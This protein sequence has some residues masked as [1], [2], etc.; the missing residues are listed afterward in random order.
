MYE[1]LLVPLDGSELAEVALPYAREIA[2]KA[3]SEITL[4]HVSESADSEYDRMH[5]VYIERMVE[6]T[7][8]G[9]G[10][11]ALEVRAAFVVGNDAEGIVDYA[12]RE[13]MGLIVMATH[14]RSGIRRWVLGSVADKVLRAAERPVL[15]VRSPG[16][17][18][19]LRENGI[20]GRV[21]VPLDGSRQGEAVIPYVEEFVAK[22]GGEVTLLHVVASVQFV[23]T[24]PGE[25][26]QMMYSAEEIEVS[27]DKAESYL[28]KVAGVLKAKGIKTKSEVGIGGSAEEIIRVADDTGADVVAMSTHGLSGVGRWALGSTADKVLQAGS[29]PVLLVRAS[30]AVTG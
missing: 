27:K 17:T 20:L 5:R 16:I 3:G 23:Y 1:K 10:G 4:L 9:A 11:K 29:A 8:Q 22:I 19:D 25:T 14:G 26:V 6:A 18:T 24:I 12:D 30:G 13:D 28:E 2:G 15:L 21:L 7:R